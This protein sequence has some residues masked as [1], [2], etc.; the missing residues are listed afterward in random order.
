MIR[1]RSTKKKFENAVSSHLNQI[2]NPRLNWILENTENINIDPRHG[3]K[4][5]T[6]VYPPQISY[7]I[8]HMYIENYVT[9][10]IDNIYSFACRVQVVAAP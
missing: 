1:K 4:L 8:I 2:Y 5:L 7:N 9:Q 6:P 10:I 3:Y